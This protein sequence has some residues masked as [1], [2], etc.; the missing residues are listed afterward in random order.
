MNTTANDLIVTLGSYRTLGLIAVASVLLLIL[1]LALMLTRVSINDPAAVKSRGLLTELTSPP[2]LFSVSLA[3]LITSLIMVYAIMGNNTELI[4]KRVHAAWPTMAG[5]PSDLSSLGTYTVALTDQPG[6][7]C[8][9]KI[10]D[11]GYFTWAGSLD[12][13]GV[14]LAPE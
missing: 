9:L 7:N 13:D 10:Y 3:A 8:M 2:V 1:A 12:C 11:A 6:R 4:K 14:E 5:A